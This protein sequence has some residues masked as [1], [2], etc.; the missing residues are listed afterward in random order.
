P[1][2]AAREWRLGRSATDRPEGRRLPTIKRDEPIQL[3][4]A[5]PVLENMGFKVIS[6]RVY[7]VRRES[8]PLWIQDFELETAS[9][10][11]L[12]PASVDARFKQT[13]A[14]V[15]QGDAENDS[16]NSFVVAAGL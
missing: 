13:F 14:L 9:K 10:R 12:D 6:E 2:G 15:L 7:W 8:S 5:L 4:V 16:F 1:R 3:Y 11:P